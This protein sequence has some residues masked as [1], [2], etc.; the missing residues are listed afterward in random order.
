MIV[1][2]CVSSKSN[3]CD[4]MPFSSAALAMSTRSD[5]PR[6]VA[7]GDGASSLTAASAA[8]SVGCRAAPIAQPS[9]FMSVRCASRSTA[10]ENAADGCSTTN[11]AR[12]L[13]IGGAL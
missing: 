11:R 4:E 1:F 7:C 2:K 12:I 3:V 10:A 8:V 6:I 9:Q 13:V 5:R